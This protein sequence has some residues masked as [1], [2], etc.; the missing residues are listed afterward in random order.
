MAER[1]LT[2]A[3][4]LYLLDIAGELMADGVR[5][6]EAL[7]AAHALL[8]EI[9]QTAD[10]WNTQS[11]RELIEKSLGGECWLVGRMSV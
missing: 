2:Q 10:D 7:D 6:D 9:A 1:I 11:A 4:T 5:L 3:E 8:P